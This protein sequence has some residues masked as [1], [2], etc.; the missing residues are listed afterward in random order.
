MRLLF[1]APGPPSPATGGGSIRMLQMVQFLGRQCEL[2]LIA[3]ALDGWEDSERL[4]KPFCRE[5]EFVP[6]ASAGP[7]RRI[8]RLSPYERN[9]VLSAAVQRRLA[10]RQ[11]AA[12]QVEKPA[13]LPYLPRNPGVPVV[14]DIWAY[15]LIGP[16]RALVH[17]SGTVN[18]LRNLVQLTRFALFDAFAWPQT[19]CLLVVSEIDRHRCRRARPQRRVLVV[20][21]GVDCRAMHPTGEGQTAHPIMLFSGD[22]GFGPNVDAALLLATRVFPEIQ[23]RFPDAELRLAGRNPSASVRRLAQPGITVTG[24][25]PEMAPHLHAATI[26]IAPHFTGAG[27]RTKL[28]EAMA[29]G[30]PIVTTSVG[31]EGIEAR[32]DREVLIADDPDGLCEAVAQLLGD[33]NKRAALGAAAR[34]LAEERYDWTSCLKPLE[35]LYAELSTGR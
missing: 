33:P 27:T 16:I 9:P 2:D 29:A 15:G 13:M 24:D 32:H 34:R 35:S 6:P 18:R 5:I 30:L 8:F 10:T 17:Q 19:D 23:H 3:P 11:Y 12:I 4:C 26:Y 22:M 7:A 25:V 20:P 31:I 28:L 14:L 1:L 21:N